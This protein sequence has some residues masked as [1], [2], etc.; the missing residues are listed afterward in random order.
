M[1]TGEQIYSSNNLSDNFIIPY[2]KQLKSTSEDPD[3][4]FISTKYVLIAS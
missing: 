2:H 3:E 1:I 4:W